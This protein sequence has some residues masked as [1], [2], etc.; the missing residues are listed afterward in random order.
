[1]NFQPV[2][3]SPVFLLSPPRTGSTLLRCVLDSH[4]WIHAPHELHLADFRVEPAHRLALRSLEVLGV[5]TRDLENLLWDAVMQRLL[6]GSGKSVFV[7]KTP[8]NVF[9]W[10]RIA[11]AW[12]KAKFVLLI[13]HPEQIL[14]S[15]RAKVRMDGHLGRIVEYLRAMQEARENLG[16]FRVRYEELTGD[17][18]RVVRELCDFL[19]VPWDSRMLD[20]GSR[21]H[22]GVAEDVGDLTD[23]L[24]SGVIQRVRRPFPE[25][26][27]TPELEPF[28]RA[29]GYPVDG[30]A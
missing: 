11:E 10:R 27:P 8:S 14:R 21:E 19:G 17:P 5:S 20:Y 30:R 26:G 2:T 18:V 24:R 25:H 23:E 6:A 16:G 4:P 22:V 15:Y 29:W 9:Q 1:M 12:P 7:D 3:A 28:S 13:R